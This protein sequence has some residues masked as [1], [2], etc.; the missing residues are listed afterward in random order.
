MEILQELSIPIILF[1]QGL[2]GW[3][4]PLM[5]AFSFLG[6]EEFYLLVAPAIVWCLDA[7]LGIRMGMSLMLSG[8]INSLMKMTFMNPRPYWISPKLPAHAAETSFGIPSGHSQ[9]AVVVWGL[10][11]HWIAK[12]WAWFGAIFLMLMIGLSRLALGVHFLQDVLLGWLVGAL[13]LWALI[14]FEK[15]VM[16]WFNKLSSQ[17]QVLVIFGASLAMILLGAMI[18][19]LASNWV[20]PE[21]WSENAALADPEAEPLN[22]LGLSGIVTNAGAFFGLGSGALLLKRR[23]WYLTHGSIW[24][25]LARFVL[26]LMGVLILRYGLGALFPG[27]ETLLPFAFRYLR[28]VLI[29]FWVTGL[30]PLVFIRLG[31]AKPERQ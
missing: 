7:R 30:A 21:T 4:I 24:Q 15:P 10:L 8:V 23:G 17:N 27:G 12:P 9:N 31:L 25:M 14:K 19:L 22:P 20:M 6:A 16:A 13:F 11:A 3:M 28:Y 18:K 2:G 26:G 29:G 1:L 5:K